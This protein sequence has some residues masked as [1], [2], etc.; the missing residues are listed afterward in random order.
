MFTAVTTRS[1]TVPGTQQELSEYLLM[2]K[3]LNDDR[4]RS[5]RVLSPLTLPFC[6]LPAWER[7]WDITWRACLNNFLVQSKGI[8]TGCPWFA[9]LISPVPNLPFHP[10]LTPQQHQHLPTSLLRA[11]SPLRH[12]CVQRMTFYTSGG[13]GGSLNGLEEGRVM[14]PGCYPGLLPPPLQ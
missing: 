11:P 14:E 5:P 3:E 12:P 7:S 13:S 8:C 2:N 6:S 9:L 10:L 4:L 1:R